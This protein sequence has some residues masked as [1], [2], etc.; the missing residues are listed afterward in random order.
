MNLD[1]DRIEIREQGEV[2]LVIHLHDNI[3][4]KK[5]MLQGKYIYSNAFSE[6]QF[7]IYIFLCLYII[8]KMLSPDPSFCLNLW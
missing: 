1:K 4:S 3:K 5:A 7:L 8:R 2:S 6:A